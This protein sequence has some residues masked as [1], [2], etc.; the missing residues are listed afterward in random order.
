MWNDVA[1]TAQ[2]IHCP[3]DVIFVLDESG[4]IGSTNFDLMK[5]FVSR[6]VSRMDIDSGSTRVGLVTY[7]TRVGFS[8]NLNA[9]RNVSAVLTVIASLRYSRGGTYT[10][11]VLAHVRTK[12]LTPAAGDR[13]HVPNVVV[14]LTDGRSSN[15]KATEVS[16]ASFQRVFQSLR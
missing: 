2:P 6:L 3:T 10:H 8:L 4:S 7:A 11:L 5:S 16:T 12:M 1:V 9:C 13:I 14:V 15:R